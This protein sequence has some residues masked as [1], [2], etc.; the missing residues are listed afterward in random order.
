MSLDMTQLCISFVTTEL[1]IH[2]VMTIYL[3]LKI[4]HSKT[5]QHRQ[6]NEVLISKGNTIACPDY[7][8]DIMFHYLS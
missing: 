5:D 8:L 4:V 3:N 7:N 1:Y 6:G 2:F